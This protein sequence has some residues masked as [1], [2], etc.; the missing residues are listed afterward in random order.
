MAALFRPS[1]SPPA[2]VGGKRNGGFL[3]GSQESRRS[4]VE[5]LRQERVTTI[6]YTDQAVLVGTGRTRPRRPDAV[7]RGS[8]LNRAASR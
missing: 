5:E 8:V 1:N 2:V 3:P 4:S 6:R 7:Y